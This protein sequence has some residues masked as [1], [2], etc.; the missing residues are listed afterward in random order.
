MTGRRDVQRKR[1]IARRRRVRIQ[2]RTYQCDRFARWTHGIVE[3]LADSYCK[4]LD[5]FFAKMAIGDPLA[6][7][8]EDLDF[9]PISPERKR[10]RQ[11]EVVDEML[12][13]M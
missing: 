11:L 1:G 5:F 12:S 4:H 10:K 9:C 7:W 8:R 2:Y 13:A 6:T 3:E